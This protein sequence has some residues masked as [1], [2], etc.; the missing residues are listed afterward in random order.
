L[1]VP[2]D[3]EGQE[4]QAPEPM[5]IDLPDPSGRVQTIQQPVY[6]ISEVLHDAKTRY[7]EMHKLLYAVLI[8]SWKLRHYFQS[9]K[10]SVVT[11][12]PLKAMLHNPNAT[13]NIAKWAA[14]L[15]EFELDF[16]PHHAVKSQ[17]LANFMADWT[18]P[19]CNPGA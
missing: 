15:A 3:P 6:Y 5:E 17:V 18:P 16:L 4:P 13:R 14:E 12:Y 1:E 19:P 2:S 9:H 11:L 8:A 10:I 7:L